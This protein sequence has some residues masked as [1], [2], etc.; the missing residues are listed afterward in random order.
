MIEVRSRKLANGK[1]VSFGKLAASGLLS[2]T[3][4][5]PAFTAV[6]TAGLLLAPSAVYA[7]SYGTGGAGGG[8]GGAGGVGIVGPGIAGTGGDGTAPGSGG[9]G[10]GGGATAGGA[11]GQGE[12]G[13]A[14]GA[15]SGS[16]FLPGLDG[17]DA[18]VADGGG[19]GGG[20]GA[21]LAFG[22]FVGVANGSGPFPG[23]AG[24]NGGAGLGSGS[25][26]GGGGGGSWFVNS[27]GGAIYDNSVAAV[28]GN[29]GNGGIGGATGNGGDGG[30]GGA[31][32]IMV[33]AGGTTTIAVNATITGGNGGNGG[34]GIVSG[35]GGAGGAGYV[36]TGGTLNNAGTITGGNGGTGS[37]AG[38]GGAGLIGTNIT[39]N[40]TGTI[41]GGSS[42]DFSSR[43]PA[44]RFLGTNTVNAIGTTI[45]GIEITS[46][47]TTFNP[48]AGF[49]S[50]DNL[51][52]FGD[53]VVTSGNL[54]IGNSSLDATAFS[55]VISGGGGLVKTGSSVQ[56][57]LGDNTY[58]GLTDIDEGF[59]VV[60]DGSLAGSV[61]NDAGFSFGG[62]TGSRLFG[63]LTNNGFAEIFGQ[64]DGDVENNGR[65]T[66]LGDSTYLGN[67]TLSPTA[68]FEL[69]NFDVSIGGLYS[70]PL[71][72]GSVL[73]GSG[74]LTIDT[75]VGEIAGFSG[76][77]SGSGGLTKTGA[78]TQ[79]FTTA[80]TYTGL[81]T[82][83]GGILVVTTGGSLAG[84]VLNNAG[85]E[86]NG[87]VFGGLTNNGLAEIQG[88]IDGAVQNNGTIFQR[89]VTTYLGSFT[90]DAAGVFNL[91]NFNASVGS[92]AGAG[93]VLLGNARLTLGSDNTDASFAGV[94]GGS[95]GITKVGTGT[96]TLSG[97]NTYTG[98]TRIDAG[99]LVLASGG[100]IAGTVRNAATFT[101][102]GTV[103][104]RVTNLNGSTLVSTGTLNGLTQNAGSTAT[105][106][107]TLNGT[108]LNSGSL[109][110][111]GNLS[112]NSFMRILGA[113]G[114]TVVESGAI[115]TGLTFID[116]AGTNATGLQIDGTVG[117]GTLLLN[118]AGATVSVGGTGT[119]T[120]GLVT[121]LGTFT[122]NGTVNAVLGN[123]GQL[124]NN[125]TWNGDV[126]NTGLLTNNG[127]WN[128]N[129]LE[130]AGTTTINNGT[131]N[132][133]FTIIGGGSVTNNGT[134]NNNTATVSTIL[135]GTFTNTGTLTGLGVNVDGATALFANNAG[136]TVTLDVGSL[137]R[138]LNSGTITNAGTIT[139]DGEASLLGT[140][141]NLSGGIWNGNLSALDTS[142]ITNAGT[143]N[144]AGQIFSGGLIDNLAGANWNG[145][146]GVDSGGTL[147]NAGTIT[148]VVTNAGSVTSTGI[149]TGTLNNQLTGTVLLQ[150]E[151]NGNIDNTG[152]ITL[153]G[154]TTGITNLNQGI[155]DG[156]FDM[157][158]FNTAIGSLSGGGAV[159]LGSGT[160]TIGTG[161]GSTGF[162]GEISGSGGVT[163]VG[164]STQVFSGAQTYTGLTQIDGGFLVVFD[165]SLAGSVLNNAGFSF[166]G[167]TGSRLFGGLTNTST[168]FAEMFGQVDGAVQNDGRLTSLG[169]TT[170]LSRITQGA[171][172][173]FELNGFDSTIGSLAGDGTVLLGS[174]TLT[175]GTDNTDSTFGGVISGSGALTK[176][177]TGAFT[178]SGLNLYTGLTT[179]SAGTLNVASTGGIAGA[180]QNNATFNN[181]GS[182]GGLVTNNGTLTS[183]GSLLGGLSNLAGATA[184]V[185]GVLNGAIDNAGGLTV[186][187]NLSS[188][189]FLNNTG[190]GIVTVDAGAIWT[191]LTGIDNA[192]SEPLGGV[193]INGTLT[194]LGTV[195]NRAGS[196]FG[197][198]GGGTLNAGNIVNEGVFGNLT[199]GS[200]NSNVT[201]SGELFN[202]GAWN[203]R[204]TIIG[205]GVAENS[206]TWVNASGSVSV[207]ND[208]LFE[209]FGTLS[210]LGVD[211]DGVNAVLTSGTGA[212]ITLDP[213][214][215]LRALN[216]GRIDSGG[217]VTGDGV[218]TGGTIRNFFGATWNGTLTANA[219]GFITN[220]GTVNGN[221]Q[222]N[223]G[224]EIR[225]L[226]G[227]VWT[228]NLGVQSGGTLRNVPGATMN[229]IVTNAGLFI[230]TGILNGS[231]INQTGGSAVL[232]N[233]MNGPISNDGTINL[234][235][236]TTGIG[237]VTQGSGG[238][239]NLNGINTAFGSLAGAGQVN[240]GAGRLTTGSNNTSTTFAGV[241]AGSG[242][243]TKVG[244]G[245]FTLSGLNTYTGTT[246]VNA[247]TL[248]VTSTGA[249]A[250]SVV[251]SATFGNAGLVG[252]T[253]LN[254]PGATATN[255]GTITGLVTNDGT[256]TSTGTLNG[257]LT[258]AGTSS[259]SGAVNGTVLNSGTITLTGT[260]TG[261]N[262]FDQTGSGIFNLAGFDT[263]IGSLSGA[264]AVNLGSALLTTG[265]NNLSTTF[266]GVIAGSGGLTKVGTGLFILTGANTYTGLTTVS[267][268]SLGLD[269]GATIAGPVLNNAIF[270]NAGIV[271]GLVTNNASLTS[272]GT[273][274]G[275]LI[276][277]AGATANLAGFIN[278]GITN[279]G[280]ALLI[281]NLVASGA[282]TQNSTG[283]FN[284][285]GFAASLGSLAGS[286]TV[287]LGSGQLTVGGLNTSTTFSGVISGSGTVIKLGTGTFTLSGVN[288]YTG[289][290]FVDAGTLV[291]AAGGEIAGSVRNAA[292][293]SNAGTVRGMLA[294]LATGTATNSGTILAGVN[295]AGTFAST[296][297][298]NTGLEN[299]GTAQLSGALNGFVTNSGTVTLTGTTTGITIFDQTAAGT[300]NLAGFN[301]AV[302]ALTGAGSV[303]LGS[304]RLTVG[305]LNSNMLFS[306]V[307]GGTGSL[308]K[309]GTGRFILTGANTYSGGTTI[310]GGA[311]QIGNG[312]TTG[313]IVGPVV[314]NGMLIVNRSDAY[315]LAGNISGSG[316]FAQIGAGTTTLTGTNTYSGGTLITAGRLVGNTTSL[317]GT[318]QVDV[319]GVLEF[320]QTV[321]GTYAG[322]LL[323]AG[324]FDKTGAGLLTLTGNSSTFTGP[325]FV[326][327]GELRVNGD[328]R[329]SVVTVQTGTTL[330]GNGTIG[331]LVAQSG[332]TIAPG[333]S[334]GTLNVNG[335]VSLAAGSTVQY[336]IA[337][338]APWDR[339]LATGTASLNGTAA[340]TN[341][342]GANAYAFGSTYLLLQADG[343]RTGTFAN[344]TGFGGFGIIYRPELIYT[345]TQVSLRFAPN[346][347]TNIVGNTPLT[348]NQRSVVTRIDTAVTAGYNPQPLFNIYILPN[349]QLP[350]AFDQLSG[351]VYATAAGVGIEQER[352]FKEAVLGRIGSVAMAA[353]ADA[354]A[355]K[356][357][358]VWGQFFGG[359]G[360]GES[361]GNAASFESDR[362]GFITGIDFGGANDTSSWR[363]GVYGMRV[364]SDVTIAA[365][366][367]RAE[368]QQSG[369]GAYASFNTGGFGVALGGYL[370]SVDLRAFRDI[371][372]PG[373]A[374][375]DV[376]N[377]DG[378][379]RQ[380]FAELSYAFGSGKSYLRPFVNGTIGS[381]KLD[382]LTETGGPAA[383]VMRKQSYSTG[384][385]T[386]GIDGSLLVGKKLRLGGTVAGRFQLGDRDPQ[387]QLALAAAPASAFTISGAQLDSKAL[388]ARLDAT[389]ELDKNISIGVGYTGLIGET[390]TDH[391]ARATVQVRF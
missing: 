374:E 352:L 171:G 284:L 273:I 211:V 97:V 257:G 231:L 300:F 224:G 192:S 80:Q 241:I 29:G 73:L 234:V 323:G 81:T 44:I 209:N 279:S 282:F 295:N 369:G 320:N 63:D 28:G 152:L 254:N 357:A 233:Q 42:G 365:R 264:G 289:T 52:G 166:G 322:S 270:I 309:V 148:G 307:I 301:T 388:A 384:T 156:T 84:S 177:G 2:S 174:A 50:I 143:V 72:G 195:T 132:G 138:A 86:L 368:V 88:Q 168:G 262:I 154:V 310:T 149:I 134:W 33:Q 338:T 306:G 90:Q 170:Y 292:T 387:A 286:G 312:G 391:G 48:G 122:N 304:A 248:N 216:G 124:T 373:F 118:R 383:L 21:G 360:D 159:L 293:F 325:S 232:A 67:V 137:L 18:V 275:G 283:S 318:I 17:T 203:G 226:G 252:G 49:F 349:A 251:N 245:T 305:S 70:G 198:F 15:G 230:S 76:E 186:N 87:R 53:L 85:F 115:W 227:G 183:T 27:S 222:V 332:S 311:L 302:G 104:G 205:G 58:T 11:G 83:D 344:T 260:T 125:G 327:G 160:L 313:S 8:G 75:G 176:V 337:A 334:P 39:L 255:S 165:G 66:H 317:Q 173:S 291:L 153:T 91:N 69:T 163:K 55:G 3:A 182:V 324:R 197:V 335:N 10:G 34:A 41:T 364:Q 146:I 111:N 162:F 340:F 296:G 303:N 106:S 92:L 181:D 287:S 169:L 101:N 278:G 196:S 144:G 193:R 267:A 77:I 333:T 178:L 120:A 367:S 131:F 213:G 244:T 238:I 370:T 94:I 147:T 297:T 37:V 345:G 20:G 38:L 210:G 155:F 133:N 246:F 281:G 62:F 145:A 110:V 194:T 22:P 221:G 381:F 7:Q 98:Q 113:G 135:D 280:S 228:G 339:I 261:I 187:G 57:L 328:L 161:S 359:W 184:T 35:L 56:V 82:I 274:N 314:N 9:G 95:G 212:T 243:L 343:G 175:T 239:F 354:E 13:A 315:T 240:L 93:S 46:G 331:G 288:T 202:G 358:G 250:G 25:G 341:L 266:A 265:G 78:G 321:A 316:M 366:V 326:I 151:M 100:Q 4:L 269:V 119:L 371:A 378:K 16:F 225:N 47:T 32:F 130:A 107:G 89:G 12:G 218:A 24:G 142:T 376:G 68:L 215:L 386:G 353:R 200:V 1:N 247:G 167:L 140:I 355:G 207:I 259:L 191:G 272:A 54:I 14:G 372:L 26:G 214:S 229:G 30:A 363:L 136:G 188:D 5:L 23:G 385:V 36:Q 121:N 299:S 351:E 379:A 59:L 237:A 6:A 235:G 253:L 201:N 71:G 128:G 190:A 208:G 108:I 329:R 158:G 157:A 285:A 290:T 126:G 220:Q 60:F 109:T 342:S 319:P 74:N 43:A 31:G 116:N 375:T 65:I 377:T 347:L 236:I 40:N 150:G 277:N 189:G 219:G 258:N 330:S 336:E 356:G 96:Q 99:T 242:G 361:D 223:A 61:V 164:A 112:S 114:S 271:A 117:V 199:G 172:G 141:Q 185:R 294:N 263:T 79:V 123:T 179:V 350:G 362:T 180:V 389:L 129:L 102:N 256:F 206:G 268:G 308:E 298:I 127:T 276:N 19:G 348:A 51:S 382:A 103:L 45:G 105:V 217:T 139:G 204:F 249:I 346:L 380:A 390:F 64:I